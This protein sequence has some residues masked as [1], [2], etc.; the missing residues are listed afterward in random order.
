MAANI[1]RKELLA[2][3]KATPNCVESFKDLIPYGALPVERFNNLTKNG[4]LS[5]PY[6]LKY[7][8]EGEKDNW[9]SDP[10]YYTLNS[11]NFRDEWNLDDP[12]KRI[13]FFGCSFTFGEGIEASKQFTNIVGNHFDLNVFNF[14]AGGAGVEKVAWTFSAIA[15]HVDLDY[16]VV[17]LPAW[18]RQLHIDSESHL[19]NLIP[20]YPHVGFKKLCK[21]LTELDDDFYITRF[22]SQV[23]WIKDIAKYKGIKILFSSWDHTANTMCREMLP[24]DTINPFPNI[25]DKCARDNMHP[26]TKSQLAHATQI[27]EAINDRA[28]V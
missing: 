21:T 14:G 19:I 13:G 17:T 22:C 15:N 1:P 11:Y 2:Y 3:A 16:A 8:Q 27:I 18:Y 26:G 23:T 5:G 4:K 25:D 6:Q 10:W 9:N 12:R 20:A 24:N 7:I 28:W